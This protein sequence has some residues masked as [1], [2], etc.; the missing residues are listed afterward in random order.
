MTDLVYQ[1]VK[2]GIVDLRFAEG[3]F[4]TEGEIATALHVSR[5]PVREA[6]VRLQAEGLLELRPKKGAFVRPITLREFREVME[7]R[8]LVETAGARRAVE[9]EP[10]IDEKLQA[11]LVRQVVAAK[12][13]DIDRFLESDRLFHA[14]IVQSADNRLFTDIYDRLRDRQ[15]RMG[16]RAMFGVR[17]RMEQVMAEHRAIAD[18]VAARRG[19]DVELAIRAHLDATFASLEPRMSNDPNGMRALHGH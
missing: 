4:L 8:L 16:V 7:L 14:Q 3:T 12:A 19:E 13:S 1:F 2:D 9:A 15:L 18:A 10:P 11:H 6:F 17:G 5:T